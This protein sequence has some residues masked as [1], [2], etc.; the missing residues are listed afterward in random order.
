MRRIVIVPALLLLTACGGGASVA[1]PTIGGAPQASASQSQGKAVFTLTIPPASPQSSARRPQFVSSA[2]NVVYLTLLS[3]NGLPNPNPSAFN[4]TFVIALSS[5]PGSGSPNCTTVNL[6]DGTT[7]TF[8]ASEPVGN[9]VFAIVAAQNPNPYG[10]Q[11]LPLSVAEG[12]ALTV[13]QSG[14]SPA[15]VNLNPV[16]T[17]VSAFDPI[18]SAGGTTYLQAIFGV[19]MR[20]ANTPTRSNPK[21]ALGWAN[22]YTIS[23]ADATGNAYLAAVAPGTMGPYVKSGDSVTVTQT[24]LPDVQLNTSGLPAGGPYPITLTLSAPGYTLPAADVPQLPQGLSAPASQA[25]MKLQCT[26]VS[27]T[28]VP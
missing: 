8:T 6:T 24:N 21:Y 25:T 15:L 20:A 16:I 17:G 1:R 2:T 22:P 23:L 27:C 19:G 28:Q 12:I 9:D 10:S 11:P 13:T 18:D 5:T 26:N 14:G 4:Q 7:C 3:A